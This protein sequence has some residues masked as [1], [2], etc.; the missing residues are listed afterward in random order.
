MRVALPFLGL[1]FLLT[2]GCQPAV[3]TEAPKTLATPITVDEVAKRQIR[4]LIPVTGTLVAYEDVLL[5]PKLDGRIISAPFDIGDLALPQAVLVE[6]ESI[7]YEQAVALEEQTLAAD[8]ARLGLE[9]IPELNFDAEKVPEVQR[10]EASR[11]NARR[12]YERVSRIASVSKTE[13]DAAEMEWKVSEANKLAARTAAEATLATAKMRY[14]SMQ[15]AQ[16]R[17]FDSRMLVPEPQGWGAWA[18]V[19]GPVASPLKYTVA[20]KLATEGE[21]IRSMPTTNIYRLVMSHI[22][23]LRVTV[24]EKYSP[25]VKVGQTVEI[26]VDAYPNKVFIGRVVRINPAID[27]S[28]RTF[29]VEAEVPNLDGKLKVGGFSR[30][31]IVVGTDTTTTVAPKAISVFAGVTKVFVLDGTTVRS[32]P[33]EVGQRTSDWVEARGQIQ[34]GERVV[35]SGFSKLFDGAEV[36]VR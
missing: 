30:G 21:M 5:A 35:T 11:V 23:K 4:R 6:L 16:Q 1:F 15:I 8:L 25:D 29:Q 13:L 12:N 32:V 3:P 28:T 22:L 31:V 19:V 33:V 7:D 10:A 24:P 34:P 14:R 17:L 36:E 26:Q 9:N 27:T 2:I 18:A 20:A